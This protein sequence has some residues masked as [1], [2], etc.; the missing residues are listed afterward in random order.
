MSQRSQFPFRTTRHLALY[1]LV[2]VVVFLSS[3]AAFAQTV[4]YWRFEEGGVG[5]QPIDQVASPG[6]TPVLDSSGNGYD[7]GVLTAAKAPTYTSSVPSASTAQSG[8]ANT[9]ALDFD[10]TDDDIYATGYTP[11]LN[12]FDFSGGWTVE[13]AFR[14]D[15]IEARTPGLDPMD[16]NDGASPVAYQGILAKEGQPVV[17][18]NESPL[19]LRIRNDGNED[20][21]NSTLDDFVHL[22]VRGLDSLGDG[23]N[24]DSRGIST[25]SPIVAG[26]WYYTALV[27]NGTTVDMYLD[28]GNGYQWQNNSATQED[29]VATDAWINSVADWV[30]GREVQ[31]NSPANPMDGQIDEVRIS[32]AALTPGEFLN[33]DPADFGASSNLVNYTIDPSQSSYT[34]S[35]TVLAFTLEEQQ[36]G[37]ATAALQGTIT[38]RLDGNTLSFGD[39]LSD[40]D[41][42]A[43]AGAGFEPQ[44][45]STNTPLFTDHNP[46]VTY[47][48]TG[49][50]NIGLEVPVLGA[51]I[52]F[53]DVNLG[54][55]D[56]S[57]EFGGVV[58]GIEV[59]TKSQR[60]D[61]YAGSIANDA[62]T[63]IGGGDASMNVDAGIMTRDRNLVTGLD[64]ITIPV[65]SAFAA[66]DLDINLGGQIVATRPWT[67]DFNLDG[68]VNGGDF[69]AYQRGLGTLYDAVD[70]TIWQQNYGMSV[71]IPLGAGIAAV[72]E[73]GTLVLAL[74]IGLVPL[75]STR[76]RRR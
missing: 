2:A 52:A 71:P 9:R 22:E 32:S 43:F 11:G 38:A 61:F 7:M 28:S 60:I 20:D 48:S 27:Y 3:G 40:I 49:E 72:P 5:T 54:I 76:R 44:L 21:D 47:P 12:D 15:T 74:M 68:F 4:A 29:G 13:A 67:G 17:G 57:A 10:G 59:R 39:D 58:T 64:T 63:S 37:S 56:G 51:A 14:F 16:P 50:D 66:D 6:S 26:Q 33:N 36:P 75:S 65:T 46:A 30:V 19:R 42:L 24:V 69:L 31:N 34:M 41:M 55:S 8:L 70:L 25:S 23:W 35:G 1:F 45:G 73:P 62:G 53:R 18:E